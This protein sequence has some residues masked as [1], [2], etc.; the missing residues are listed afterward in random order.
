MGKT[1]FKAGFVG[2]SIFNG[3]M[4]DYESKCWRVF[5]KE[6]QITVISSGYENPLGFPGA[7]LFDLI[8]L[9]DTLF[10][11]YQPDII[12]LCI[13]ANHFDSYGNLMWPYG[14]NTSSFLNAYYDLFEKLSK[15]SFDVVWGGIPPLE[16]CG[17]SQEKSLEWGYKIKN[18]ADEFNFISAFFTEQIIKSDQWDAMGGIYYNNLAVDIHP[19][20][21]GQEFIGKFYSDWFGKF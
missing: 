9:S 5:E 3:Y 12:F 19:N 8:S 7:G 10:M 20:E 18:I 6:S 2:D 11:R 15:Q 1:N 4:T 14:T 16:Q 17:I 21:N 13:G